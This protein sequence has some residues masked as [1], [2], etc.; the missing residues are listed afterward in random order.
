[1]KYPDGESV[2][3][4]YISFM[5]PKDVKISQSKLIS[6]ISKLNISDKIM[7][8]SLI[9]YHHIISPSTID[10]FEVPYNARTDVLG[11][12]FKLKYMPKDL[13]YILS[14]FC[15]NRTL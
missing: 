4:L 12:K 13:L 6:M 8:L 9:R 7:L 14:K 10:I 3:N 11:L 5:I 1:M 2:R 15:D